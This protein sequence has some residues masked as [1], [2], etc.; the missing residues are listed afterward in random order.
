MRRVFVGLLPV[1]VLGA[2]AML[3]AAPAQAF[4]CGSLPVGQANPSVE[5]EPLQPVWCL[6]AMAAEPTTRQVDPWGGWQDAFQTNIPD[7][8]LNNGDMGYHVFDGLSNGADVKT[9]HFVNNNHW[10]I[11]MSHDNGGAALSPNQAFHFEKGK[12]VLEADVAA[13]IPGYTSQ[14]GDI[15]WPEIDW[16]TS[17]TPTAKINDG[18]YL[19]GHFGGQ[20]AAGCRLNA[21]RNLICAMEAENELASTTG[22]KPPCFSI[23]ARVF[24]LSAFQV[25]GTSHSGFATDFNAPKAAWRQCQPNQMDIYCRDRFRLE[26]SQDGFVAY[27]NGIEFAR[28]T[29]WPGYAQIPANIV[30]G[31]TP[32]YAYFGEW[33][34]FSDANVYRFH[35]GRIAVNPHDANG[36]LLPPS[37]APSYCAGQP[38]NSCQ[39]SMPNQSGSAPAAMPGMAATPSPAPAHSRT[40]MAPGA[41]LAHE[42]T[43]LFIAS[44]LN[45]GQQA[46]FWIVLG[47]MLAGGAAVGVVMWLWF[48]APRRS[49]G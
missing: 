2:S 22:D 38:G 7:G 32:V 47:V 44:A 26:W 49:S 37:T 46:T 13:G 28:D 14:Q 27:V 48:G 40:A 17:P 11:D 29:G 6:G 12:L 3:S 34:D 1:L 25:C 39:M 33:G 42:R 41:S 9:R 4:T 19:Y 45:G 8:H 30:S 20:W 5:P 23:G 18:L 16:S 31:Q 43:D 36:V 21:G 15:V 24:E 10:M 35:W